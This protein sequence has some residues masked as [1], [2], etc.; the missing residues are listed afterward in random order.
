LYYEFLFT[1]LCSVKTKTTMPRQRDE[2]KI[3]LIRAAALKLVIQTG[4]SGLKMQDVAK[5]AGIAT[6]T[7]YIYYPSK[8]DLINELFVETKRE[9]ANVMLSPENQSNTFYETFKK[10]WFSYFEFCVKNPEKMLFVEQ[11]LYS[12]LISEQNITVTN[13]LFEPL[14]VFLQNAQQQALVKELD[15][16]I[17]K[18]HL[19]GAIHEIIKYLELNKQEMTQSLQ[20]QLFELTWNGIRK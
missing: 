3:G 17:L 11:F 1:Y 4:F 6:G 18:A 20:N 5:E 16:E 8:E 9:I 15:A 2:N 13:K 12:G 14:N 7:L 19:Q 10:M